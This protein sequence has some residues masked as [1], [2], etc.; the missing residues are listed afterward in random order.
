MSGGDDD[1]ELAPADIINESGPPPEK[2]RSIPRRR[3]RTRC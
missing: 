2:P 3:A 1:V